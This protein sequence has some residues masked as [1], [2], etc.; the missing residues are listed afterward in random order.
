[1]PL[2]I[3]LR[4]DAAAAAPVAAMWR[5][6]ADAGIDTNCCDLGYPPHITLAVYPDD[7]PAETLR[8]V[9]LVLTPTWQALPITLAGIGIF[10]AP[11]PTLWQTPVPTSALLACHD[12]LLAALPDVPPHPHYGAE[13]WVPHVTLSGPLR[14]PAAA[15]Q[16]L[17]P[18]WQKVNGLL[19]RVDLVRFRPVEVLHSVP[20]PGRTGKA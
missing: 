16:A 6:L 11:S 19:D 2:A 8:A 12:A 4:L 10:P 17:L 5:A 13:S 18:L 20:M 7:A 3:T 1:M 14:N 15:L 9:L